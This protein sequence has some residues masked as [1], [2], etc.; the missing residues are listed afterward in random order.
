MATKEA[1]MHKPPF[2]GLD[3]HAVLTVR[4]PSSTRR[5]HGVA[6]RATVSLLMAGCVSAP[7]VAGALTAQEA[8]LRAKPAAVLVT[9]RI[10]GDVVVDCGV[11]PSRVT[12]TAFTQ[13][14][15]GWFV[16]GRGYV[17]TN[18]HVVFP[19]SAASELRRIAIEEVWVEPELR[20]RGL[21]PG[22]RVAMEDSI[23][24]EVANR[25]TA[26]VDVAP[27]SITV[28]LSNGRRLSAE[29]RKLSP[30]L[31]LDGMGTPL[32]GSGRDLALLQVIGNA[33]PALGI[34]P[35]EGQIGDAL[36]VLSFP[37]PVL[38]HELLNRAASPEASVTTGTISGFSQDAI[39]QRLIQTDA[40]AA[41]GSS[42]GP[43]IGRDGAMVG[44][45]TFVSLAPSSS[46]V[47]QGFNFLIPARDVLSFLED[48]EVRVGESVFTVL[49]TEALWAFFNADYRAAAA[50]L[51]EVDT[52]LRD[53]PDV[54]RVLGE[55]R[56][57]IIRSPSNL[58]T[59]AGLTSFVGAGIWLGLFG[60]RWLK[61]SFG[62]S[63]ALGMLTGIRRAL[64]REILRQRMIDLLR[65]EQLAEPFPGASR[66][67]SGEMGRL[68]DALADG[69]DDSS[70]ACGE[71]G[72]CP[73]EPPD[74]TRRPSSR[75]LAG[76]S[77]EMR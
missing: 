69:A 47:V 9:S 71:E 16:D 63:G 57:R 19:P 15:S 20:A 65:T 70:R 29:V 67:R 68:V 56:E 5:Q 4:E 36:H 31:G 53:L 64:D 25:A 27:S 33:F 22:E 30:P 62:Q 41:H 44:V 72:L 18:A 10:G 2:A 75:E 26:E 28:V 74:L 21:T 39:G 35:R 73:G 14:G 24:R 7:A 46:T 61:Y 8:I 6:C 51:T 37:A 43:A 76:H 49:W 48:T 17:V 77:G 11:G 50:K 58:L 32:P 34:A 55:A 59:R 40:P 23:R 12:P 3:D 54:Q 52:T 1:T 13:T 45:L 60:R 42:G 66:A 38:S